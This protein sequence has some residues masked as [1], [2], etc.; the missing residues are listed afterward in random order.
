MVQELLC[1]FE[2][3]DL[4]ESDSAVVINAYQVDLGI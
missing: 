4:Y 3:T 1:F 2:E